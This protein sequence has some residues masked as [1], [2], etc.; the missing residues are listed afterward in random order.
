MK[1][2]ILVYSIADNNKQL[3]DK[4]V[5]DLNERIKSGEYPEFIDVETLKKSDEALFTVRT[6]DRQLAR[7]A[8]I[9][10]LGNYMPKALPHIAL[11][12]DIQNES[13]DM[14]ALT[15]TM[16]NIAAAIMETETEGN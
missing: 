4:L 10:Y 7:D 3:R 1:K 2:A 12:F 6:N 14:D 15:E 16:Q 13:D 9:S 8:I 11:N 5:A